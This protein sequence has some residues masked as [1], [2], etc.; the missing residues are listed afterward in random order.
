[1]NAACMELERLPLPPKEK[2]V[3][4]I[5]KLLQGFDTNK[6]TSYYHLI[7]LQANVS[8][9]IPDEAKEIINKESSLPYEIIERILVEGQKDGSVKDFD[10]KKLSVLFWTTIKGFA[11]NKAAYGNS[12]NVPDLNILSNM[13]LKE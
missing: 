9:A 7:I 6:D 8:D 13:F 4:A 12:F 5:E 10:A 1:M 3:L 11:F 2:I